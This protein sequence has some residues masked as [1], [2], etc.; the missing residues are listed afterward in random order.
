MQAL[1]VGLLLGAGGL[2]AF[3]ARERETQLVR[4]TSTD[5]SGAAVPGTSY[6]LYLELRQRSRTLEGLAAHFHGLAIDVA[7]NDGL[8]ALTGALVS[9]NYFEVLGARASLGRAISRADE[10]A[11]APRVA[12]LSDATWRRSFGA[13]PEVLGTTVRINGHA[14]LVIGVMP[15]GFRGVADASPALWTTIDALAEL[16]PTAAELEPLRRRGLWWLG[17]IGRLADRTTVPDV[18]AELEA[19]VTGLGDP[20]A[21]LDPRPRVEPLDRATIVARR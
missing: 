3:A 17:M 6:P 19:I 20:T 8:E 13:D 11:D 7:G 16:S 9:G 12:L 21:T 15:A 1:L 2:A 5:A 18:A 14:F 10:G 4:V